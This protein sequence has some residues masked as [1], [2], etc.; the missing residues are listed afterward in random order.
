MVARVLETA[1]MRKV[2][3]WAC[4]D[5]KGSA[6]SGAARS[7]RSWTGAGGE[8]VPSA[9]Q[10]LNLPQSIN[11][12]V[13]GVQ[14]ALQQGLGVI[15]CHSTAQRAPHSVHSMHSTHRQLLTDLE[16]LRSSS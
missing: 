9:L 2:K 6:R 16:G 5:R 1:Y 10:P 3:K 15:A 13:H 8:A 11:T 14:R 7:W 4:C 12:E